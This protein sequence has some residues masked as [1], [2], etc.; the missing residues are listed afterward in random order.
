MA[1]HGG[2]EKGGLSPELRSLLGMPEEAKL[3]STGQ[4][5]HGK[6]CPEDEGEIQLAINADPA[7][8]SVTINFGDKPVAW[9]AM[10][11]QQAVEIAT[12]LI[13]QARGVAKEPLRI[14]LH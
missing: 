9:L 7:T 3:G 1:H 5:T 8:E 10:T 2:F 12:S 11:P 13:R 14:V 4:F 6:L